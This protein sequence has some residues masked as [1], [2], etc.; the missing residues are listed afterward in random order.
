M[1]DEL[2]PDE[3]VERSARLRARAA[4]LLEHS[5]ALRHEKQRLRLEA[6][7]RILEHIG[8]EEAGSPWTV[9]NIASCGPVPVGSL[10]VDPAMV[11]SQLLHGL[12]VVVVDDNEDART[13][14][15]TLLE[16]HGATVLTAVGAKE[17]LELLVRRGVP[18]VLVSDIAMP[19]RDGLWLIRELR[20][21]EDDLAT[22]PA[23]AVTARV[24]DEDRRVILASGFQ[25]HLP[26][27]TN[28]DELVATIL[29]VVKQARPSSS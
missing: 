12:Y 5:L 10:S 13:I 14:N 4:K 23:I 24:Q 2:R 17:A 19:G 28:S 20:S 6:P 9:K 7:G 26:K 29:H 1:D 8:R 22:V 11:K 3:I 27:P 15:A 16:T 18:D 25:A 21:R